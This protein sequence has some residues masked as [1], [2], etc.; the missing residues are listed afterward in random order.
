M[1]VKNVEKQ[2]KSA[3]T[4]DVVCD[5][6]EFEKAVD[7]VYRKNKSKI[8]IQG[9]RKGKAPRMVIEGIY[10]KDVFYDDAADELAPAAFRFGVDEAGLR[11]VGGPA[12]TNM[13]VSDE[14]EL[15]LSFRTDV[16]PEAALGQYRG[17]EAPR[18][19]GTV[20]DE[21]IDAELERMRRR[22]A[23]I[24]SAERPAKDGD[25]AII[26]FAGSI[27]GVPFEGGTGENHSLV[28]GSG[29]FIPG[30]EEQVV[31]MSAGE[32]KDLTV[33]FPA[34]YHA[35]ELAGREAV[36]HVKVNDIKEELVPELDD[37]FVK[38]V[39]EFDTLDEYRAAL[40][41]RMETVERDNADAE[42]KNKLME[43]ACENMTA[44]IPDGLVETHLDNILRE[45]DQNMQ[46]SGM[47]L[48]TY[49]RYMGQTKE[50][51]RAQLRPA[52]LTRARTEVLLEAIADAEG[53]E[54]TPEEIAEEYEKAAEN[55]QTDLEVVKAAVPESAITGDI[56]ARKAA[57]IIFDTGIPTEP[58]TEEAPAE[59]ASDEAPAAE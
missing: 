1:I 32:E 54:V 15:T 20:T 8:F 9:F 12:V 52:A 56:R 6:A 24:V 13:Q 16:W 5:A 48:E 58:K 34:D 17:L 37:E 27:D 36:F 30:F 53:V 38:D 51:F 22:N 7:G 29:S 21:Q 26:D 10:G 14:R 11:T 47:E 43:I 59:A 18:G 45:Y 33:T 44:D 50:A 42:F 2:E 35:E 39:S 31:G 25:T 40:R 3:V 57:Q 55:Y 49:L 19:A 41:G 4:F 46:A 23:R 28:L